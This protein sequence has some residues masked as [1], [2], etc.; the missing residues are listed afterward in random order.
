MGN[1]N[2]ILKVATYF[3]CFWEEEGFSSKSAQRPKL[4]KVVRISF[5]TAIIRAF[6]WK[7]RWATIMLESSTERSTLEL[8]NESPWILPNV[9]SPAIPGW[10]GPLLAEDV[11]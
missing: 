3:C 11:K 10:L 9:P 8:S 5:I 6:V 1:Y 2:L 7:L 4:D